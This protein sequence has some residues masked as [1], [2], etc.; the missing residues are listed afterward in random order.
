MKAAAKRKAKT[1]AVKS[2]GKEFY[3]FKTTERVCSVDCAIEYGKQR[4]ARRYALETRKLKRE[5][6]AKDRSYQLRKAQEAFNAYIVERDRHLGC[7]S[8]GSKT[9]KSSCGHFK[10]VGAHPALRFNE[11]NGNGQCWWNCNSNKS[12]NIVEYRIGLVKK[13]GVERVEE[14][15]KYHPPANW[16]LEEI[17]EIK[18]KYRRKL[19]E[20]RKSQN[21]A[22]KS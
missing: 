3:P 19:K 10:T 8:C 2:C 21:E 20:L 16:T 14:L 1:C 5:H 18:T 6:R 17:K 12:G 22:R 13:I 15:E 9:A 11:D 4:E 7:I